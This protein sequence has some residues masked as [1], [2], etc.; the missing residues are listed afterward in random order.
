[1]VSQSIYKG[2]D[3]LDSFIWFIGIDCSWL[4]VFM[5]LLNLEECGFRKGPRLPV[6]FSFF[7]FLV[8]STGEEGGEGDEI[9]N[10]AVI[11]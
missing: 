2:G 1:M 10:V 9:D 4:R 8:G 3:S 6:V 5:G 7:L 11:D